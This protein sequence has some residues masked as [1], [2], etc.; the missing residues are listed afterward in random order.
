V[1]RM[2]PRECHESERGAT[3]SSSGHDTLNSES[4]DGRCL[5]VS[6]DEVRAA[7]QGREER[8]ASPTLDSSCARC[9]QWPG[10]DTLS[11]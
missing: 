7:W 11:L 2:I 8:L 4:W 6:I 1:R 10:A 9:A 5:S 3:I